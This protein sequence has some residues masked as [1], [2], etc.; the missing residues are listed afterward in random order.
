MCIFRFLSCGSV[1]NCIHEAIGWVNATFKM[2]FQATLSN[3]TELERIA[4]FFGRRTNGVFSG[5]VG[6]I[7]G[8]AIRIVNCEA[9][10]RA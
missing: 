4:L 6:A 8:L 3:K 10:G 1:Y 2:N 9:T 7:D 5:V